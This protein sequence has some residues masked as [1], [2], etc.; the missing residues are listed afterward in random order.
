MTQTRTKPTNAILAALA[1]ALSFA[2]PVIDDGLAPSEVLGIALAGLTA[3]GVVYG[4]RNK[5][6]GA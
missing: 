6:K 3:G 2:I 1:A 4:V 5:P